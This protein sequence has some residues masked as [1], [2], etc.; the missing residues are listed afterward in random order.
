MSSSFNSS[1]EQINQNSQDHHICIYCK[2]FANCICKY[3]GKASETGMESSKSS[4]MDGAEVSE[5][6]KAAMRSVEFYLD[7]S[8][9]SQM[10]IKDTSD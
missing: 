9:T 8:F 1:R 4:K 5:R 7:S 2:D 10:K 6:I 3:I